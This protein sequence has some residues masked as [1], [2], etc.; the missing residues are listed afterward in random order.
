MSKEEIEKEFEKIEPVILAMLECL[1]REKEL[2]AFI[3]QRIKYDRASHVS[4]ES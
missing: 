4:E 3:Q 2:Q 1:V